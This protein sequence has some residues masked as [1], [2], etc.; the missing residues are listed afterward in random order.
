MVKM[1]EGYD[2]EWLAGILR[3]FET[4]D[5]PGTVAYTVGTDLGLREG[6]WTFAIVADFVDADAYLAYDAD[7][8]HGALRAEMLTNAE[9]VARVQF[10]P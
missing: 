5:C 8:V 6:G 1:R 2:E 3:G 7:E 4:L 9:Q 10:S